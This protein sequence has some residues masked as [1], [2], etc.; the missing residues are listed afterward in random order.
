MD[1]LK[2]G[3]KGEEVKKLQ[4]L[5]GVAADGIFGTITQNEVK[6]FQ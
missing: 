3:S 1:I 2:I 6:K 5:L 4:R